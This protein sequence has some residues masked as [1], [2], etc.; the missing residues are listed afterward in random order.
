MG[1]L[2]ALLITLSGLSPSIGVFIVGSDVMHQAGSA[3]LLCFVAAA[4]LGVAIA[5]VYAE[6]SA[7]FPE[8]G[9]EYTIVGRALGP[10]WGFAMLGLNLLSFSI[11][12]AMTGLGVATYLR[13][14]GPTLPAAPIAMIAV[15]L[16]TGL[17]ILNVR[18]N[19]WVTGLFLSVELISLGVV[20]WLGLHHPQ[21]S[22]VAVVAH[23]VLLAHGQLAPVSLAGLGIG[24]AAAIYAF[25]GYGSVVYLGEEL[26]EAPR[27]IARVVFWALGLAVVWQVAPLLAVLIGAPHLQTLFAAESPI[28]AFI[29][30]V[31]GPALARAMSL[32]VAIALFNAMI[33]LSLMGGR[34]LYSSGR[35]RAWER[36]SGALASL[37]P[38]FNSPWIATLSL[39]AV[40]LLWCL[41]KLN[42]L[43][44][45]I[46]DGTA[47][48][49]ICMCLA[50]LRGRRFGL[51]AQAP[52][53]M[54]LFP[55]LP[56]L[57][58]AALIGVG[59]ADLFD[60]DGRK[61][62]AASAVV[63]ALSALYYRFVL[64]PRG[65]WGHRGP[66]AQDEA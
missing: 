63:V 20:A 35:D 34:Q 9:G 51:T 58:L 61:G 8:T 39:G 18:I 50:A 26:Q 21:R 15:A 66:Q 62:V 7:A 4:I 16:C 56:S 1:G 28:S 12:P 48:I 59:V 33:A 43:V 41:V 5:N 45:L 10:V 38:R 30:E 14:L 65:A 3:T 46:G 40:S 11:G 55:L 52:Y 22:V 44:V 23:P 36:L 2:G 64:K 17:A 13:V 25:D 57:A 32:G 54:P 37:H 6:L 31:G 42:V 19:A 53:R 29:A 60:A 24:A 27:R 49:Y 47:A